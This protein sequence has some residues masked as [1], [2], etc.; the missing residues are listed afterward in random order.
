MTLCTPSPSVTEVA[1]R[2][3][4]DRRENLR[5]FAFATDDSEPHV[6]IVNVQAYPQATL[7]EEQR[8][9]V[10]CDATA[11]VERIRKGVYTATQVLTATVTVAIRANDVTNCLTESC[12][13]DS[14]ERAEELDRHLKETGQVVGPLHGLPVSI[15]DHIKVKGLDT[16]TGYVAWAYRM[17]AENDALV[18]EI[19]RKS[20]AIIYVKTQNPQTL[21]SL[22]TNNNIYGRTVNPYNRKLTSGGSSGGEGALIACRGSFLGVGT[23][24]GGSVRIP[25]AHCGLYGLKGSVARLPHSGLLGSHDGMDA[26]VGCVGPLARS[27]RDLEL[28]CKVMLN[29]KPWLFEPPLLEMPWK[30]DVAQ[31]RG[32]PEKLTIAILYDDGVVA[33]HPPITQAMKKY[34]AELKKAG[35]EVILWEPLDHLKGWELILRLYFLDGGKEYLEVLRA[36]AELPVPQTEWVLD[37][38]QTPR[39][40]TVD[41]I[42]RLNIE[43][44]TFRAK[45]LEHWNATKGPT[46]RPVDAILCP[47]AP[48]LA[49]PHDTTC[50]WAYSSHWNLL[51]LPAVAF[52]V[53]QYK[54]SQ[55]HL[56]GPFPHAPR[57]VIEERVAGQWDP[58]TYDN[59]PI[60]LQLV[61]R[62]HNEEL[63]LGILKVVEKI[64]PP[65]VSGGW[66]AVKGTNGYT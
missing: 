48:T 33:P 12:L 7:T 9:I 2:K 64:V 61:G 65:H 40:L 41:E 13:R 45:A 55:F 56:L 53:G 26:I 49:P 43:R 21:L 35:H 24:I 1:A 39:P 34:E 5:R 25:A 52:P 19:L 47:V 6:D 16:S 59:A 54:A 38:I 57:N 20:G 42:F 8:A 22:E 23:D 17:V 58:S 27:A 18:V 10:N 3:Q 66:M 28:F 15:K 63:L 32:L 50:W 60:G 44:E 36:G 29:A 62:R 46:G 11:L 4:R 51:D 14:F 37:Q 30:A 31:G